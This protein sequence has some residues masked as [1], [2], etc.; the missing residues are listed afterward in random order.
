MKNGKIL[1]GGK[2]ENFAR[3]D[4]RKEEGDKGREG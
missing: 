2:K 4:P 1:K 3:A